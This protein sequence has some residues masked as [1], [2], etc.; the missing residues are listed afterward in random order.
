MPEVLAPVVLFCYNR[1]WHLRQTVEALAANALAPETEL[2][3]FSDGPKTEAEVPLVQEVRGYL[4]T[5]EGFKSTHV[6]AAAQNRGLAVSVIAGVSEVLARHERVV[7]LEDDMLCTPDF[8]DFMN[9]ALGTYKNRADV[10]SVTGYAPPLALPPKYP[11][12]VYLVPRTSSWGWGTWRNR[13]QQADWQVLDFEKLRKNKAE[14]RKLTRGGEDLWPMLVK[15]QR[16]VIDSWSVR[17][18]YSQARRGA[19]SL[20]PVRSKIRNIGTDGSGTNFTFSTSY[21][22][23]E[24][25]DQQVHFP[26]EL[27]PDPAVQEVLGRFYKLPWPVKIKNWLRYRI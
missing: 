18:T 7:V 17:W 4:S 22:G 5:V 24:L 23:E 10:F 14:R 16:G 21:Y 25:S 11:H 20:Y 9:E 12:D 26:P 3:V 15:Q 6:V 8:L 2:I 1:P 13:W 19:Y 27:R